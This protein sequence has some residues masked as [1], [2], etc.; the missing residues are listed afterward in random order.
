MFCINN[1]HFLVYSL[2]EEDIM[3]FAPGAE[4]SNR[5]V[6]RRP[7]HPAPK[8]TQTTPTVPPGQEGTS[9]G[10]F[11]KRYLWSSNVI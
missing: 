1:L 9:R 4:T 8:P 3:R 11:Y 6:E 7:S 5:T 2:F 10:K